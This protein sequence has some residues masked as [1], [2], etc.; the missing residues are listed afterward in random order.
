LGES[1]TEGPALVEDPA[2]HVAAALEEA[3]WPLEP[4]VDV[5]R[6]YSVDILV[7]F[8]AIWRWD[9]E[10]GGELAIIGNLR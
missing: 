8:V 4:V 9:G 2:W 10:L 6:K 1:L 5:D 3:E 7:L